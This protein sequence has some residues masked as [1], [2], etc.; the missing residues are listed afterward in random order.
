MPGRRQNRLWRKPE[1]ALSGNPHCVGCEGSQ[2]D[3]RLRS[4]CGAGSCWAVGK[5][6]SSEA[7]P[8][9]RGSRSSA[10]TGSEGRRGILL[11]RHRGRAS[12][13]WPDG[14]SRKPSAASFWRLPDSFP[15]PLPPTPL[16]CGRFGGR[17]V[18]CQCLDAR[19]FP[20]CPTDLAGVDELEEQDGAVLGDRQVADL[21][22]HP[23]QAVPPLK[24]SGV[25]AEAHRGS[26][27]SMAYSAGGGLLRRCVCGGD[28]RSRS[29]RRPSPHAGEAQRTAPVVR[30]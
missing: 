27:R 24:L 2:L 19:C 26:S 30:S 18:G 20:T 1:P 7:P 22:D 3:A 14:R 4:Q 12:R 10:R 15:Q 9:K 11:S 23:A 25:K 6:Q 17:P 29:E 5:A 8:R 13:N 28:R 21:V 16:G